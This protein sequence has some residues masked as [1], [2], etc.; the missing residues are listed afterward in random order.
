MNKNAIQGCFCSKAAFTLIEL[1]VVVLIIGILAAVAV[2]QY[3]KAVEKSK[4]TQ[5][6]TAVRS[7]AHAQKV[8]YLAN[9]VY[10]D[11]FSELDIDFDFLP[12]RQADSIGALASS[13]AM[14]ANDNWE[15][16]L[17]RAHEIVQVVACLRTGKFSC[18]NGRAIAYRLAWPDEP[19]LNDKLICI[20][21][22][23]TDKWCSELLN[24]S[25]T[26]VHD[27]YGGWYYEIPY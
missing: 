17:N 26:P 21:R 1:L 12:L 14:R 10:A 5:L 6:M 3:K 9:G 23:S 11:K 24:T 25:K 20:A 8:Y 19:A 13:D 15:I 18:S 22:S 2:P 27:G 7:I 4:M 16:A